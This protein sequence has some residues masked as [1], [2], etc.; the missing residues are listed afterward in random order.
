MPGSGPFQA[1]RLLGIDRK[2]LY[3]RLR[4]YGLER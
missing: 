3:A 1:A 2:T 4:R